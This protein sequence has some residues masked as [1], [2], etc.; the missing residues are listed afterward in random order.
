MKLEKMGKTIKDL[1]EDSIVYVAAEL[2]LEKG[3][4]NVKMTD[5]AEAAGVGVAS[6]Y[7]WYGTK[8]GLV[9]RAGALLWRDLHTLFHSVYEAA[10]FHACAGIE[11]IRRLFGVYRTLYREH[12]DFIRFV[13]DFD[14][15]VIRTQPPQES[16]RE[17]EASV[18][19]FFPVFLGAYE[20]GLRDGSVRQIAD[21]RLFY[22]SVCHAVMAL[23]QKLLR[24]EIL[25][26]D[27]FGDSAELDLLL[28]MAARYL[29]K[30]G[31]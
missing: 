22:D 23:T 15:F 5:V 3:I 8:D 31:E 21:P 4:G 29:Q 25:A 1:R 10:D 19:N 11:Q 7:R 30:Q 17:Y 6:L 13:G 27:G 18:L 9:I 28:D 24:G 26:A 14:D 20:T 2:F 12:A 16:L